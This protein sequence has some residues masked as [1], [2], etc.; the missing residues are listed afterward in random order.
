MRARLADA[1]ASRLSDGR[2]FCSASAS[3]MSIRSLITLL[4]ASDG[5]AASTATE[6]Y[7]SA[8]AMRIAR[9]SDVPTPG[10]GDVVRV[11]RDGAQVHDVAGLEVERVDRER[12]R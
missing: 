7:S 9:V 6:S 3:M 4:S 10:P 11:A 8:R 5:G 12:R 1:R 2:F